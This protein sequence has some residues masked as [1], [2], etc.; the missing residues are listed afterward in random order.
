MK[1]AW[2]LGSGSALFVDA[3]SAGF[4]SVPLAHAVGGAIGIIVA[5]WP[6][7]ADRA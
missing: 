2:E 5:L 7:A 3:A 6:G 1:T 4:K